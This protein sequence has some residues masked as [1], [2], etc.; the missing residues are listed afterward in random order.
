M[1]VA[2]AR[3]VASLPGRRP[4]PAID[5]LAARMLGPLG[6]VLRGLAPLS[7][8]TGA[9]RLALRLGSLGLVDHIALRTAALDDAVAEMLARGPRQLVLLGAGLDARAFRLPG[10]EDVTVFEVDHPATQ[11][12]KRRR[13]RSL[14]PHAREVRFVAVDFER[15]RVDERLREEGFDGAEPTAWLWEGVVPYLEPAATRSTLS[16]IAALSAPGSA[17]AVTYGTTH[18]RIWLERFAGPV[19][20]GFRILGEPLRGLTTIEAFHA[21]LADT[22]WRP[23]A[24]TG[25]RDWR[26]RYGWGHDVLLT[27]EERLVVA[28]RDGAPDGR[29]TDPGA[30]RD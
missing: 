9:V 29:T 5:P 21:M 26:A 24:D 11:R 19:H 28:T 17:L 15:E 27:I 12:V 6:G 18:D 23:G 30:A 25:P 22:G 1:A 16:R 10:L 2:F 13:A 3:G 8:R 7:A 4:G 14:T 20:L